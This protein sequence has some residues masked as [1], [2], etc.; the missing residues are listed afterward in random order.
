MLSWRV[1]LLPYLGEKALYAQFRLDE[2]W[3][4]EHNKQLLKR[5]PQCYRAPDSH[6]WRA[7]WKTRDVVFT[8]KHTIFE[9]PQGI[10]G[11]DVNPRTILLALVPV[12]SAVAW[13]KPDGDP[14]IEAGKPV[15]DLSGNDFVRTNY[16]VLLVDGTF[17]A[18][19]PGM[20]D[21]KLRSMIFRKKVVEK[22]EPPPSYP[23]AAWRDFIFVDDRGSRRA[24]AGIRHLASQPEIA[25][26]FLRKHLAPAK[27]PDPARV[28][29]LINDLDSSDFKERELAT[30]T[31]ARIGFLALPS[32]KKKLAEKSLPLEMHKRL[33]RLADQIQSQPVSSHELREVRAI[34][35]L[36]L[37]GN[38][39]AKTLLQQL[40]R[41][42]D[43]A[44]ITEHARRALSFLDN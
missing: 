36:Q 24:F 32:L 5:M 11:D 14:L 26:P 43:G 6:D 22:P 31:L 34:R 13:T 4:S 37:I 10:K 9:G 16:F 27:G 3:D 18:I 42:A 12:E 23:E 39:E 33:R 1:A 19:E 38:Q 7:P 30:Q 20:D 15:P 35:V 8:G 40:A 2:P 41:G 17:K 28:Q 25:L 44:L 21:K 29:Q